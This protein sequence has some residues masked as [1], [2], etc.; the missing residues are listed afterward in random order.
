M[1]IMDTFN[2]WSSTASLSICLSASWI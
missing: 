1:K 2:F